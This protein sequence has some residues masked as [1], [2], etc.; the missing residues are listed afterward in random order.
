MHRRHASLGLL[1][2]LVTGCHAGSLRTSPR[3]EAAL[4]PQAELTRD[5]VLAK[6]NANAAAISSL[7]AQ[8]A[9][10]AVVDGTKYG[11]SGRLQ[12]ER[13]R[14]FKLVMR[15]AGTTQVDIGS[16]DQGFWIWTKERRGDEKNV[17]VGSYNADGS[18]STG[19]NMQ[20]DWIIEAMGLR[21]YSEQD[22]ARISIAASP[23]LP[24]GYTLSEKL[25]S[26][27]GQNLLKQTEID[28][29]GLPR[30]RKLYLL[31][32]TPR[33]LLAE[34]SIAHYQPVA[35]TAGDKSGKP[36]EALVPDSMKLVWYVPQRLELQVMS[37]ARL[38]PNVAMRP[39]T[40]SE[41]TYS[42][43]ARRSIDE[44]EAL[45][46]ATDAGTEIRESLPSH[47]SARMGEPTPL[48]PDGS[49]RTSYDPEPI[50]ADLPALPAEAR[51]E[52]ERG[53]IRPATP[54]PPVSDADTLDRGAFRDIPG[55]LER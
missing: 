51:P 33:T 8:P 34:A 50:N 20:P 10:T 7:E 11:L 26:T 1:A 46:D 38:S 31:D 21:E 39:G 41:P 35:T 36:V 17:L 2:L 3:P 14:N 12:F 9:L 47:P 28:A 29:T 27:T 53:L 4:S 45:A 18:S 55:S 48:G 5:E 16:N 13:P 19:A 37:M 15:S 32:K 52:A 42:G 23:T 49:K 44:R 30:S 54:R 43:Y 40:F 25:T 24:K 22:R 6:L